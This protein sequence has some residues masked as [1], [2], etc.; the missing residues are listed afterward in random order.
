M[1]QHTNSVCRRENRASTEQNLAPK[2][3]DH[4]RNCQVV[5]TTA[6]TRV[7]EKHF[8]FQNYQ[9]AKKFITQHSQTSYEVRF[10]LKKKG[11]T[12]TN[13]REESK[14]DA[15]TQEDKREDLENLGKLRTSQSH[16]DKSEY[17]V[18]QLTPHIKE[19]QEVVN[20]LHDA[21][22]FQDL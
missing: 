4:P 9:G 20:T 15:V 13:L 17:Q 12:E 7:V 10:F 18:D 5:I 6:G 1:K 2:C 8:S 3:N 14:A 19:L 21:Q 11:W 16:V 22:K